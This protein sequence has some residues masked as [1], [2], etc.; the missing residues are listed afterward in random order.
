[1]GSKFDMTDMPKDFRLGQAKE[2]L[3]SAESFVVLAFDGEHITGMKQITGEIPRVL[4]WAAT[5]IDFYGPSEDT[6]AGLPQQEEIV[7]IAAALA[8]AL[9]LSMMTYH[10]LQRGEME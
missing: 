9:D 1:M 2:I 7:E 10:K 8:A 5:I 6:F 3:E 4:G